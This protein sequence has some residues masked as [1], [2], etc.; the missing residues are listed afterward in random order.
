MNLSPINQN[1]YNIGYLYMRGFVEYYYVQIAEAFG[2]TVE[3]P[4]T[5]LKD[6]SI[7]CDE[8]VRDPWGIGYLEGRPRESKRDQFLILIAMKY[9]NPLIYSK[10]VDS[11]IFFT[12]L[13]QI[14]TR[15][16]FGNYSRGD[17]K[18]RRL[19]SI[20]H[21]YVDDFEDG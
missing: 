21:I 12:A 17:W 4:C 19:C 20:L 11:Y 14:Q 9:V 18:F 1:V 2:K 8:I 15:G 3:N 13:F 5:V 6:R 10:S 16:R 7:K